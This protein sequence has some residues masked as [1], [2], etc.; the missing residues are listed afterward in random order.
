MPLKTEIC[1]CDECFE[2]FE[3]L[4]SSNCILCRKS[5]QCN[6]LEDFYFKGCYAVFGYDD[7]VSTLIKTAKYGGRPSYFRTFGSLMADFFAKNINENIDILSPIPLH[8]NR[9]NKRGFNQSQILAD[10]IS[11]LINIPIIDDLLIRKLDTKPQASLNLESRKNNVSDAFI[12][13]NKYSVEAKVIMLI[14][15]IYTTGSTINACSKELIN[16]K[17]GKVISLSLSSTTMREK[18]MD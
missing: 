1:L 7:L 12:F 16:R 9:E 5:V 3:F 13:N 15:D 11:E 14:D 8:K 4:E 18:I 17:A 6:C 2:N 10:K